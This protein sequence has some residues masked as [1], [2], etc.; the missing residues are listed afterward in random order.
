MAIKAHSSLLSVSRTPLKLNES[1][2]IRLLSLT[3]GCQDIGVE[4]EILEDSIPR[5][6]QALKLDS[7]PSKFIM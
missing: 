1:P 4:H 6:S 3:I 5:I 2:F 7:D